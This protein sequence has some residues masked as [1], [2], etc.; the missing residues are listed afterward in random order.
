MNKPINDPSSKPPE[1]RAAANQR[2]SHP[3]TA[4]LPCQITFLEGMYKGQD[5]YLGIGLD[6]VGGGQRAER[7]GQGAHSIRVSST[8]K[9]VS[10]REFSLKLQFYSPDRDV[11]Y[12]LENLFTLQEID[13][14]SG[15]SPVI[16]Y[17]EGA[18]EVAGLVCTNI[19]PR[20]SYQFEAGFH[21]GEA[22]ISLELIGGKASEHR[23]AKP[24][25]ET[26]LT[27][28]KA[29]TNA[30]E[31]ERQ[32]AIAVSAQLLAA[33]LTEDESNQVA[34]LL[35]KRQAGNAGAVRSLSSSAFIQ[36]AV[37]GM[38]PQDTLA[39]LEDKLGTD[40]AIEMARTTDGAGTNAQR[41]AAAILS[42]NPAGLP[43]DL[44]A[45]VPELRADYAAIRQAIASQELSPEKSIYANPIAA[46]RLFKL[47][48]CGIKMRQAGASAI[49]KQQ[50]TPPAWEALFAS[51][52]GDR[53][54]DPVARE[55][56]VLEAINKNLNDKSISDEQLQLLLRLP[57][58]E[59]VE[60]VRNGKPYR[61]KAD[62]VAIAGF[63]QV[64]AGEAAWSAFIDAMA[65][66]VAGEGAIAG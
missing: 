47:G 42:G 3:P 6:G 43:P 44:A 32:G 11:S 58:K 39:Q 54:A 62:F 64:I 24:L 21:L 22:D 17:K 27:A 15:R 61:S 2:I 37:A 20:K 51:K 9:S 31:R 41:L 45:Q 19:T 52:L 5:L 59:R 53:A 38:I 25:I 34:G 28:W 50:Q 63:N 23:F 33:C 40:L 13:P 8:F 29:K 12:E 49:A 30:L 18:I 4:A 35:E 48:G 14:S 57:G 56:F 1:Q 7:A 55:Q 10:Q 36:A 46:D 60:A 66:Q 65:A 26:E 16:L